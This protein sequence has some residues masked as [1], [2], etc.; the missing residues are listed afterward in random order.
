M[1]NSFTISEIEDKLKES[2]IDVIS[3]NRNGN[4][5]GMRLECNN[6]AIM[7][8]Y[9]SGKINVQGKN[10]EKIEKVLGLTENKGNREE[11]SNRYG[12]DIFVV[13]GQ[14]NSLKNELEAT[15]RRWN[16]NPLILNQL[17]SDGATI[18]EKLERYANNNVKFGIVIATP[19]D[20]GRKKEI[21]QKLRPRVRQ[22]VVLELG[23]L[24][25][26]L[27]REKVAILLKQTE[28]M[29]KPSDID[30]L[31]YFPF[32]NSIEEIKV[33]LAKAMLNKG[34]KIDLGKL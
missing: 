6:G 25:A 34:I 26:R 8:V 20:E 28:D 9:D 3:R 32:S 5:T 1:G 4:N 31:I 21:N 29:E 15:L 7:T 13:Y 19:D 11:K 17:P 18:I 33:E 22:N 30:G 2:G 16:L 12:K 14:D 23:I 24:L 27:G 10:K